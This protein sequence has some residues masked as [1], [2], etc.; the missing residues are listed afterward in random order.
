M[1]VRKIKS[2][3]EPKLKNIQT[4]LAKVPAQA[5]RFFVNATPI[6]TGNARRKTSLKG[7]V[8]SANYSYAQRLNRGWS[9]QAPNGM[10]QPTINFIRRIVKRI[11]GK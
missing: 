6:D 10:V 2:E 3:I 9:K 4:E 5:H 11:L 8:I 1:R 7:N